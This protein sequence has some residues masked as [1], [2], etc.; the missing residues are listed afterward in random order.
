MRW[1]TGKLARRG[2][3][4]LA[5]ACAGLALGTGTAAAAPHEYLYS[6]GP[7]GTTEET[8]ENEFSALFSLALDSASRRLYARDIGTQRV[9]GFEISAPPPPFGLAA[10]F[11]PPAYS[12]G[13]TSFPRLAVDSTALPSAGNVYLNTPG[14][15]KGYEAD[16]TELV[17]FPITQGN[18]GGLAVDLAG[19]IWAGSGGGISGLRVYSPGGT[20]LR[21]PIEVGMESLSLA[22]D[23]NGDL[24]VAD[25]NKVRKLSAVDDYARATDLVTSPAGIRGIAVD[26]RSHHLF[27]A[28]ADD[29]IVEYDSSGKEVEEFAEVPGDPNFQGIA[30][31]PANHHVYVGDLNA[32]QIEAFGPGVPL[33]ALELAPP[34]PLRNT[35]ATLHGTVGPEGLAVTACRFEWVSAA[36]FDADSAIEGH[37]GFEDLSSGGKAACEGAIPADEDDH[38]VSAAIE[39]LTA[40]TTYRY[41]IVAETASA[42]NSFA[43]SFTTPAPPA[44]ETTGAQLPSPT[45]A[46]LG[47][48]VNPK[49]TPTDYRFEYVDEADFAAHGFASAA[50]TPARRLAEVEVQRFGE[51][52]TFTLG[53]EGKTTP[54]LSGGPSASQV[55]SALEGLSTIGAGNVGVSGG[56]SYDGSGASPR[57]YTVTFKGKFSGVDVP[58]LVI[59]GLNFA[60]T[61]I[62]GGPGSEVRLV[63]A[64]L[65]GLTPGTT[66]RYRLLA[67]NGNEAGEGVGGAMI[68]TTH[69]GR[70]SN[71]SYPHPPGNDR[72]Y[73]QV[74]I[75]DSGGNPS[76]F[77]LAFSADGDRAVYQVSGGTPISGS[78]TF[79]SQLLAERA[80]GEHPSESWRQVNLT[81][82]SLFEP[83][84]PDW[85]FF[86]T[87][88][89]ERFAG[90]N[91]NGIGISPGQTQ[92]LW[93]ITPPAG[94]YTELVTNLSEDSANFFEADD[95]LGRVV[96]VLKDGGVFHLYDVSDTATP[97]Q[98]LDQL[99]VDEEG[100]EEQVAACGVSAS[101]ATA[102]GGDGIFS[103][104]GF[105]LGKRRWVSADGRLAFFPS[106]GD[107]CSGPVELYVRE[108]ETGRT[109]LLSGP[110]VSGPE[111]SAAFI[112][113]TAAATFFWTQSNLDFEGRDTDPG[114]CVSPGGNPRGASDGDVYRY[115]LAT[116][117]LRCVTCVVP[118]R[119]V[120]VKIV[121]AGN[122]ALASVGVSE[123]GSAV[124]FDSPSRL[125]AGAPADGAYRV[126]LATGAL[127]YVAPGTPQVGDELGGRSAVSAD[128]GVLVFRSDDPRLDVQGATTNG[129]FAQYYRYEQADRSLACVSCPSDGAA[130]RGETVG[131]ASIEGGAVSANATYNGSPLS[132]DGRV[133]AFDTPSAL[134]G[135]DQNTTPEGQNPQRGQDV[136]EWRGGRALLISDGQ[137]NWPVSSE[138]GPALQ[139]PEPAAV[140]RDG[141]DVY[142]FE[143]AQLTPDALDGYR[144]LYDA[145]EGGGIDFAAPPRECGLEVC[146]GTPRGAPAEQAPGTI[147][148]RSAGDLAARAA[149]A[150]PARAARRL[151]RRARVL[152]R[153]ARRARGPRRVAALRRAAQRRAR[154]ARR[155]ARA[156]QRCRRR[157]GAARRAGR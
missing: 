128:G 34:D 120:D 74:S 104:Q 25:L 70:L 148:F 123:D 152:R 59:N 5:L 151:S 15:M 37:D 125:V 132:V 56:R 76:A 139:A 113:A 27:V 147:H 64:R 110:P 109:E 75:A 117:A 32:K 73:E 87:P 134:V 13:P 35:T 41:R 8:A 100:E 122:S 50:S 20:L 102:G 47:G 86:P 55:Q 81:P 131:F 98:L 153:V 69:A 136:Y 42:A 156:A 115:Q 9:Y 116:G 99:P 71:D 126:E 135:A 26:P 103:F 106:K 38:L 39:G 140:S 105:Y 92:K 28:R 157:A 54:P 78:G 66:Y 145:R 150:R 19:R 155:R 33:P 146:Q 144:R 67:E 46:L 72:A 11:P 121:G 90:Y 45:S 60:K 142:F 21:P 79:L 57:S 133:F 95:G 118:G 149:C 24:Y 111:C 107:E 31:D 141:G 4:A 30:V 97:P 63:G 58:A 85:F 17:G 129:G 82:R 53:F 124:Y 14:S 137:R 154:A 68:L 48:R 7:K 88:G 23:A 2:G 84:A 22:F 91:I 49:G 51:L 93:R 101:S 61:A 96:T 89:L 18:G 65:G 80:S 112:R 1:D 44:V 52:S 6:F 10:G 16:G 130:P 143:T 36:V 43:G 127:D 83:D 3:V 29:E 119:D 77:A 12:G 114:G 138:L 94:P 62:P 40:G 108:V